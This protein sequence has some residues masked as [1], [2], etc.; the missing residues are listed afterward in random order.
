MHSPGNGNHFAAPANTATT[1]TASRKDRVSHATGIAIQHD[2][3]D[4]AN[5]F[6]LG[7]FHGLSDELARF[8]ISGVAAGT[9]GLRLRDCGSHGQA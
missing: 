6:P 8:D 9:G 1:A 5:L 4:C 7:R 2:I 3:F